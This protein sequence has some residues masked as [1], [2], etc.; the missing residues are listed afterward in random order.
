MNTEWLEYGSPVQS[1]GLEPEHTGRELSDEI[2]RVIDSMPDW[3]PARRDGRPVS[4]RMRLSF[5][6]KIEQ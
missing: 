2:K 3:Q 4:V 6:F 1:G 5:E